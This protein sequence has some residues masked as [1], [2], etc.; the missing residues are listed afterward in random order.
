M[1][2]RPRNSTIAGEVAGSTTPSERLPVGNRLRVLRE[3]AGVRQ[4]EL[5]VR[6]GIGQGRLSRLE[7]ETQTPTLDLV[8]RYLDALGVSPEVR[9]DILDQLAEQRVEVA[10]LRRLHRV[11]LRQHQHRYGDMERSATA[12]RTWSEHV[13]PGLFQT[14]DYIRAMCRAWDVPGLTDVE[15]IVTGR[16]E[17]QRVLQDRSKRFSLIFG[18][19]AL[20][21]SDV[22]PEVMREQ[23][24]RIVL[25][26]VMS[27]VEVGVV[28]ISVMVPSATGFTVMDDHTVL[29]GLA[30]REVMIHEPEEVTRYLD[31]FE[32]LRPRRVRGEALADLP[33]GV[34]R[35]LTEGVE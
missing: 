13:V 12:V 4:T 31:I 1:T 2:R 28:P 26:A 23:L 3:G 21:T 27:H 16:D 25:T 30:T 7:L 19:A 18:E 24:D 32:R 22:S 29:V 5:A 9:H 33:R 6:M 14:P 10:L 17:R 8:T 11:G 15:G 34:R 35:D 20:R